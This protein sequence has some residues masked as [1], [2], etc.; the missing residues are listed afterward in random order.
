MKLSRLLQDMAQV[1]PRTDVEISG[2]QTRA[3]DI[4]PGDL[5][6]AI[7]G[8][9]AD[10]HDYIETALDRGAAAVVAQYNPDRLDRVF[11]VD[12]SRLAAGTIAARFYGDPS[13]DLFLTGVTGTNGKTT[14]TYLLEQMFLAAGRR[15][16]VM[17][18]INIRY[19]GKAVDAPTTT[20]DAV[21]I[22][23]TLAEMKQAGITHVIMEVSSHGL[24]QFRVDGCRFDTGI[25]PN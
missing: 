17:G 15:C 20:P 25:L 4:V 24:D 8:Y 21:T 13:K 16:G 19:N 12:H 6:L 5:F 3:Q 23:K 9:A 10:G 11:L 7:R 2:I 1:P 22:Q 18:T 14:I